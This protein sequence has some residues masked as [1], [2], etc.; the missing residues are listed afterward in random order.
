[1]PLLSS[2]AVA[3]MAVEKGGARRPESCLL[4]SGRAC[5]QGTC[6][7]PCGPQALLRCLKARALSRKPTRVVIGK[8]LCGL[9]CSARLQHLLQG[10]W[11]EIHWLDSHDL[12]CLLAGV[13]FA[14]SKGQYPTISLAPGTS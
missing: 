11:G 9:P 7:S 13:R 1:M 8:N 4:G 3:G 6:A 12:I 2:A 5:G 10:A 14:M